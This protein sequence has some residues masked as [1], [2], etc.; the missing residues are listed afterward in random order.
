MRENKTKIV[1]G[2]ILIQESVGKGNDGGVLSAGLTR[3][4]AVI[5]ADDEINASSYA[6]A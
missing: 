4:F 6:A 2:G 5:L 1:G 3:M